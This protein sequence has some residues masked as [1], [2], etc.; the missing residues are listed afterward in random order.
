MTASFNV[1][2]QIRSQ[3]GTRAAR[4]LRREG[5]IPAVLYGASKE[6]LSLVVNPKEITT[7][8]NSPTGYNSI[9]TLEVEGHPKQNVLIKD[10]TFEP[11]RSTLLHADFFRIAMDKPIDVKVPVRTV[12]EAKGV[13]LEGGILEIVL[14]EIEISCLPS[15]IPDHIPVDVSELTF[16][17]NIRVGDLQ[18][19]SRVKIISDPGLTVAHITTVKEEKVAEV[20]VEGAVPE[21]PAEPEVIKKGKTVEE[22]EEAEAAPEK[23]E[24]K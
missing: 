17:K 14:R 10:W 16:G 22:G 5:L 20:V 12:G 18:V 23:A 2:A 9:F 15:D 19:D 6:T 1:K 24:K 8:L 21:A 3:R 11:V 4:R 7:I 13:K